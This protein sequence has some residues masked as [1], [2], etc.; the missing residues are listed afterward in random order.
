M[1]IAQNN[2]NRRQ[3]Q[4]VVGGGGHSAVSQH[5]VVWRHD[6]NSVHVTTNWLSHKYLFTQATPMPAKSKRACTVN[7]S[8]DR[9]SS[10]HSYS[11]TWLKHTRTNYTHT[12]TPR[13]TLLL[14]P[15]SISPPPPPYYRNFE[16]QGWAVRVDF[17][18]H[19][20]LEPTRWGSQN[21]IVSQKLL[22]CGVSVVT[23]MS[24]CDVC[25]QMSQAARAARP[26]HPMSCCPPT[27]CTTRPPRSPQSERSATACY[28][29]SMGC[30]P[31]AALGFGARG[32]VFSAGWLCVGRAVLTLI[33]AV[34]FHPL[35][36]A[37]VGPSFMQWRDWFEQEFTPKYGKIMQ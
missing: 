37:S 29:H 31:L 8:N 10:Q 23:L 5:S 26:G 16:K 35:S 7:F 32:S 34:P 19:L 18:L 24:S 21:V 13:H 9:L 27:S 28:A 30:S 12:H 20:D 3:K 11:Q 2:T 33:T 14:P 6:S 25:V 22:D 36:Y 17:S 1:Y 15:P 4:R